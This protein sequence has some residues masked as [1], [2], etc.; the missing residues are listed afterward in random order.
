MR[1]VIQVSYSSGWVFV[2]D[3]VSKAEALADL[4][5]RMTCATLDNNVDSWTVVPVPDNPLLD[6]LTRTNP[7]VRG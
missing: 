7:A 3:P 6:A 2:G 1:Y 4:A 5:D